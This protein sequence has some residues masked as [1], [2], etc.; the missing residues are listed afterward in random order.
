[1]IKEVILKQKRDR[2]EMHKYWG[3]K[4]S[5]DL[6]DLINEY[7]NEGDTVLDPFSGYGVFC[8]EAYLLNRNVIA[9]DL[10]PVANF[11]N[12]QLLEKNI[13]LELLKKQWACI[14]KEFEPF[15][16]KWYEWNVDGETVQLTTILRNKNDVPIKAKYKKN[17]ERSAK[18]IILNEE[19]VLEYME[20]EKKHTIK[21]W[22]PKIKLI[23]NSRISAKKGMDIS[24]LFT[25]RTL[26]CHA[27]LLSL[28]EKHSIGN[29]KNLLFEKLFYLSANN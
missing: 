22:Y 3:K 12:A 11:L 8:C 10:N 27:K 4:P 6:S 29:E 2:Y 15:H 16:N 23:E 25:K 18:E 13:D 5:G 17:G 7:S 14:R 26:S 20:Y 1:M 9:S 19:D 28:I 24:S 21:D